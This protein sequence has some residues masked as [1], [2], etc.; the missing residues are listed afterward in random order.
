MHGEVSAPG[1][2]IPQ[3][4]CVSIEISVMLNSSPASIVAAGGRNK[5]L[6]SAAAGSEESVLCNLLRMVSSLGAAVQL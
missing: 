4:R 3:F 1:G 2:D 6:K 5:G